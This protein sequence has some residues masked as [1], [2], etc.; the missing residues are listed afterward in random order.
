MPVVRRSDGQIVRLQENLRPALRLCGFVFGLMLLAG[1]ARVDSARWTRL[2]GSRCE[3]DHV[4]PV[5]YT[6]ETLTACT[7]DKGKLQT[8]QTSHTDL[9]MLAGFGAIVGLLVSQL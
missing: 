2:D 3:S 4:R 8:V 1:C 9:G 6:A 5:F 7:N